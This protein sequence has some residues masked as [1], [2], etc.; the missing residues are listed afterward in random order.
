MKNVKCAL[1]QLERL[2]IVSELLPVSYPLTS[3]ALLNSLRNVGLITPLL[4]QPLSPGNYQ[5]I[6][7][8]RRLLAC[9]ELGLR[10]VPCRILQD[11]LSDREA[12]LLNLHENMATRTFNPIEQSLLINK[13]EQFFTIEEVIRDYLPLLGL[14][15]HAR[16][17]E[18][19]LPLADL[20]EPVKKAVFEERIHPDVAYRLSCFNDC[21]RRAM[22][23]LLEPLYLSTSKQLEVIANLEALKFRENTT[24][25]RLLADK[26]IQEVC[27][28]NKLP[29][30]Q[31]GER[32]RR[33]I[34]QW[35]M[36]FFSKAQQDFAR[37]KKELGL[38]PNIQLTPP[39]FFE[40]DEYKVT[41]SFKNSE[42]L[43]KHLAKLNQVADTATIR[44][45]MGLG[46]KV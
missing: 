26:S 6:C 43:K 36:P 32:I 4:V 1:I 46:K 31:R 19:L 37:Y 38:P 18:K 12:F 42:D 41:F 29:L 35:R 13:L 23:G 34:H 7:G 40:K 27:K 25:E 30:N 11:P 3:P 44:Q 28:N 17:R 22:F 33:L 24:I 9:R 20:N 8:H 5:V 14:R 45:I 2:H 10:T 21:E 15:P 16:V 39:P